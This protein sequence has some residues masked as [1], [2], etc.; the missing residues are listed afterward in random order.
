MLADRTGSMMPP[1]KMHM[2]KASLINPFEVYSQTMLL[3]S[4]LNN[5]KMD[6]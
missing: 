1:W 2:S 4:R 5:W 6:V 3:L